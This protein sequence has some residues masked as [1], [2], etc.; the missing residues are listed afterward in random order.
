MLDSRLANRVQKVEVWEQYLSVPHKPVSL[1]LSVRMPRLY[2]RVQC[3]PRNLPMPEGKPDPEVRAR[4]EKQ[5]QEQRREL[6]S[7]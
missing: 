2:M 1:K 7:T 5:L 4:V 6:G 3:K